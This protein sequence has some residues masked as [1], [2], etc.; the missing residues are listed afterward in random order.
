M[1]RRDPAPVLEQAAPVP[2][3]RR[4]R[5]VPKVPKSR[6][7]RPVIVRPRLHALLDEGI[8]SKLTV[9]SAPAGSGKSTLLAAWLAANA[10]RCPVVSI[11]VVDLDDERTLIGDVCS[12]VAS[13]AGGVSAASAG[14]HGALDGLGDD[15]PP[16]VL[17]VDDFQELRSRQVLAAF[18]RL[19]AGAPSRLR[20]VVATRHDP[21]IGLHRLRLDGMLTEIRARDLA[22]ESSEAAAFFAAEGLSLDEGH[23][24]SLVKLTEGWA[25][26]LRF[27]AI[28]VRAG[29]DVE[30]FVAGLERTERAVSE[31]LLDEVLSRQTAELR[32][33]LL[34]ASI[35]ERICGPLADVLTG[36]AD[37]ARTLAQLERD[38]LF[39]EAEPSPGPEPLR[40][41]TR[42]GEWFRFHPL[43]AAL[44]RAEA[45]YALGPSLG[46]VHAGAADWL[47]HRGFTLEALEHAAAADDAALASRLVSRLWLEI[48]GSGAPSAVPALLDSVDPDLVQGDA[49]L[50]LLAGW[51]RLRAG[52]MGEVASWIDLA[53]A[54]SSRLEGS[55]LDRYEFA[56]T[57]VSLPRARL[58][59]DLDELERATSALGGAAALVRSSRD[60]DRRRAVLLGARGAAA[61]WRGELEPATLVLEEAVEAARRL[62]LVDAELDAT[63]L[64]ALARALR[65]RLRSAAHL[66]ETVT[67][68][69]GKQG[70]GAPTVP[71]LA[72]LAIC[73]VEWDELVDADRYARAARDAAHASGDR[74]GRVLAALVSAMTRLVG[75]AED[76]LR[77]ELAALRYALDDAPPPPLL[78]PAVLSLR[79]RLELAEARPDA[80]RALLAGASAGAET[81]VSRARVELARGNGDAAAG[82][83]APV[84]AAEIDGLYARTR[85]E[86]AI[87]AALAAEQ[88]R[89]PDESRLWIE[90]ALELAEA[91]GVR[92]PFLE[93]GPPIV[94]PLRR[95]VRR[96]TAHRWL[97]AALLAVFDG[98]RLERGALP[99]ELSAPLS[100]K[101]QMILRYLPTLMS[102]QEIAGELFVSV[103]TVKT[104]LKSIYRKLGASHRREAVLRAREL[105]LIGS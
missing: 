89:R 10:G 93:A 70:A 73:S 54:A 49:H 38:N 3:D 31:Y 6:P 51:Q 1:G 13:A 92:G 48:V 18:A 68:L 66:A 42:D 78:A 11:S 39:L 25:A 53:D 45:G 52:D 33:F 32:D 90:R 19:V 9:V 81:L 77:R 23:A 47:A 8:G 5:P 59:G 43:F 82:L 62:R 100:E 29:D 56:R 75:A 88:R 14:R 84:A 67:S 69:P 99:L 46:A 2:R 96:G 104:H 95:T 64:L 83:V 74:L 87:V 55:S 63:A 72:A 98:R 97:A 65:G 4:R 86:A 41:A 36:R 34:R 80:A 24:E 58:E 7:P 91:E 44:L 102:N 21:D 26:G 60:N 85:I 79:V 17:V 27:A 57:L 50:A 105:R 16:I 103:N 30:S 22:F 37:G 40:G 94:E 15:G 28:S 61:L 76:E 12:A 20:V 101:E 71:A 35:C